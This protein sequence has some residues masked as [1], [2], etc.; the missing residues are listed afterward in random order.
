MHV[1]MHACMHVGMLVC[2]VYMGRVCFC[3]VCG[4]ARARACVCVCVCM[5]RWFLGCA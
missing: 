2:V 5:V 4:R 1:S 3:F